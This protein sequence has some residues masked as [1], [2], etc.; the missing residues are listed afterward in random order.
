[1]YNKMKIEVITYNIIQGFHHYP[2]APKFC[3]YLKERHRH[4]FHITCKFLVS[5][6]NR[7]IEINEMQNKIEKYLKA[8]FGNICEFG[9]RSC[10]D[11]AQELLNEFECSEVTVLE[12]N[13]GGAKITR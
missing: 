7:E 4:L 9:K 2:N 12:D 13:Y 5:H 1:M 11:I 6:N 10:E 8:K 3:E